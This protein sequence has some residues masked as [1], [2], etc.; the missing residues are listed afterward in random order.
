MGNRKINVLDYNHSLYSKAIEATII[1]LLISTPLVFYPY[2]VRIFNPPKELAFEIL[3]IIALMLWKLKMVSKEEVKIAPTPLN[4]PVLAFMVICT[5]SLLWSDSPMVSIL[6]LPLF[7]AGPILYFIIV[8][9]IKSKHQVNRL[10]TSLLIISS[11]LGIYGIFQYQGIDFSFWE[12]NIA[13]QQVFGLFGNVNFFAEYLIIPLTLAI[14]LFFSCRNRTYKILLLV[15][16]LA[17]GGSLILTF[18]RGSYL[19][20]GVSAIFMFIL[21]LVSRGKGFIKEYK[22]IFIFILV[23]VILLTF[24]FVLPNPLN[25]PGTAISKIKERISISQFAQDF[26]LR[27]RIA[28]WKFTIMMIKD[29]PLL[30]SGIGTFKYNSLAYQ[31]EFFNQENNRSLYPYG[32]AD[33]A[34]N[35]YLQLWAELGIVGLA[36]FIWLIFNYFNYAIK[37][38]KKIKDNYYQGIVIG[39]MGAVVAV[40]IDGIVGFPL[41]LPATLVL[42]WLVL[43][44]TS[45]LADN[46]VFVGGKAQKIK[47]KTGN[48]GL[49]SNL[50]RFKPLIFLLIIFLSVFIGLTLTRPFVSQVY[51]FYGYQDAQKQDYDGAIKYFEEALRWNPYSGM[52]YYN[53]GQIVAIKGL[54]GAALVKYEKAEEYIDNPNLPERMATC[55][56][57]KS[58]WDKAI[59]K[60]QQAISYQEDEKSMV[61]FYNELGN[62]YLRIGKA[63]LAEEAFKNILKINSGYIVAYYGLG[64][65]YLSQDKLD[66]AQ[67]EL[68]KVIE[69]APNC[70][71]A[72]HSREIIQKITQEKL[73]SQPTETSNP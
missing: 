9:N 33:K 66:E 23:L 8:N 16:I 25:K 39:L 56:L 67:V 21:Y 69:L 53:I 59:I 35:E 19:A 62:T 48:K 17:M 27:R 63:N 1:A 52:M 13:R 40:L 60:L 73:K 42:F 15:G 51:W 64:R 43:G 2:L 28:T 29:H 50:Y 12:G 44:L 71:E 61:P 37:L 49:E 54:Y 55:Y 57:A 58:Q 68:Q 20:I 26:A 72:K 5:L 3:V 14:S 11:I 41:H 10:L 34:H 4:F 30:G 22:K 7:L 70:E 31:A 36:I 65:A 32:V 47:V 24:L 45:V 38:L 6:E 18:T 46:E